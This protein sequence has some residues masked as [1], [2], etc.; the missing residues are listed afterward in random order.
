MSLARVFGKLFG[1]NAELD[2]NV[3][4]E[5]SQE[6]KPKLLLHEAQQQAIRQHFGDILSSNEEKFLALKAAFKNIQF[7]SSDGLKHIANTS[8]FFQND[9]AFL[10]ELK[11]EIDQKP[12]ILDVYK[13]FNKNFNII[14][15]RMGDLDIYLRSSPKL[16]DAELQLNYK[17]LRNE[18]GS[19]KTGKELTWEQYEKYHKMVNAVCE[20]YKQFEYTPPMLR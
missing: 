9:D 11:E 7:L 16:Q 10:K 2:G 15:Q 1:T 3:Y 14:K 8:M 12:V 20:H 6:E 4:S 5:L 18:Y 17:K 19:F 13:E